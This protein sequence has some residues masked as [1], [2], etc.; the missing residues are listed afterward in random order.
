MTDIND[1]ISTKSTSQVSENTREE[2]ESAC[3]SLLR[4]LD[5]K[6]LLTIETLVTL[7]ADTRLSTEK[8]NHSDTKLKLVNERSAHQGTRNELTEE[9]TLHQVT[10]KARAKLDGRLQQE[11]AAHR[12][13]QADRGQLQRDLQETNTKYDKAE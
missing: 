5:P 10:E 11:E 7:G 4:L 9:K 3:Q 13:T 2:L 8:A 1:T 12:R 6:T